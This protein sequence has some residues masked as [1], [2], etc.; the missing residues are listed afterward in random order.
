MIAV[1]IAVSLVCIAAGLGL[2]MGAW[3]AWQIIA[4]GQVMVELSALA[5]TRRAELIRAKERA[6]Y[7]LL[8]V[9]LM[10]EAA[11]DLKPQ[12]SREG[13]TRAVSAIDAILEACPSDWEKKS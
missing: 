11:T 5:D 2:A 12:L 1:N 10:R 8:R 7:E 9:R 13:Y 3:A 4:S 6:D